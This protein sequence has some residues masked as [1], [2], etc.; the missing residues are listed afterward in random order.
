MHTLTEQV[1]ECAD[2]QM[3]SQIIGGRLPGYRESPTVIGWTLIIHGSQVVELLPWEHVATAS[4]YY[5]LVL[6]T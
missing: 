2:V 6:L 5:V 1:E 3:K 4:K